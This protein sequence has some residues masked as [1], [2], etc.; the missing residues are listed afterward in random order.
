VRI[1][2][3]RAL[4]ALAPGEHARDGLI[5]LLLRDRD[6]ARVRGEVL[7]AL[8]GLG[9]DVKGHRPAVEALLVEPFFLDREGRVKKRG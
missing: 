8:A 9:A 1:S 3:T 2:T 6:N 5:A 7:D 4:V